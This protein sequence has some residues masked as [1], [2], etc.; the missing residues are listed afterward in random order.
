MSGAPNKQHMGYLAKRVFLNKSIKN[1]HFI[2]VCFSHKN[3]RQVWYCRKDE[4]RILYGVCLDEKMQNVFF[5]EINSNY[6]DEDFEE[7]VQEYFNN[8]PKED[9]GEIMRFF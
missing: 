8:S 3:E 6:T 5:R 4:H 2:D 9:Y 1:D 7:K